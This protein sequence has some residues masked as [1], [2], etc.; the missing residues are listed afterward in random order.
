MSGVMAMEIGLL[1]IGE[2]V[3]A[4]AI[5]SALR[6]GKITLAKREK[7]PG[8]RPGRLPFAWR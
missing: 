1:L 3:G 7:A 2:D 6:K 4:A 8:S 5:A